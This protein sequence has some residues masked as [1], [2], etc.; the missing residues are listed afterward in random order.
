MILLKIS[1]FPFS[2]RVGKHWT[3]KLLRNREFFLGLFLKKPHQTNLEAV[4]LIDFSPISRV[5]KENENLFFE[6]RKNKPI[7]SNAKTVYRFIRSRH[8]FDIKRGIQRI[9]LHFLNNTK[10]LL[11]DIPVR[12]KK[13]INATMG[14]DT[15]PFFHIFPLFHEMKE[16]FYH[17]VNP[18]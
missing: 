10:V 14:E 15:I 9:E 17:F 5:K 11:R 13:F 8:S 2:N 1:E 3:P 12:F 4:L 7:F 18:P 6:Y 16:Y